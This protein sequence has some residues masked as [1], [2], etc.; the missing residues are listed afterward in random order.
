MREDI[1]GH[2]KRFRWIASRLSGE[3]RILEVGCGTGYMIAY[4]LALLGRDVRGLD[5]HEDSVALGREMFKSAGLD[6]DRLSSGDIADIEGDFDAVIA[7]EVLEHIPDGDLKP[8]LVAVRSKL[9]PTG[10]LLVTVPN[11]RR[12]ADVENFFWKKLGLGAAL[13]KIKFVAAVN[14]LKAFLFGREAAF[15]HE[16]PSTLSSSP[17]VQRFTLDGIVGLLSDSGFDVEETDGSV[18]FSGPFSNLFFT[19]AGPV[20]RLN[21]FLRRMFPSLSANFY[22]SARRR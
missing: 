2:A 22:I 11:G 7:S 18:V 3:D 20:M 14:R 5:S 17:H 19:G 8:F 6:P 4:Q 9:R 16:F 1:Y 21:T 12:W 13:E 10:K 15:P